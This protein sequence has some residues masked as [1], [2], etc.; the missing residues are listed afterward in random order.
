MKKFEVPKI[1]MVRLL[2][3]DVV[4]TSPVCDSSYGVC[5]GYTC[6]DCGSCSGTFGCLAG[7]DCYSYKH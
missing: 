5:D 7:F 1:T 2:K 3:E 4:V 6:N